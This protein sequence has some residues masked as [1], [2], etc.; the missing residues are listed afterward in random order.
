MLS[1]SFL[2]IDAAQLGVAL[3]LGPER[4]AQQRVRPLDHRHGVDD[5]HDDRVT[6]RGGRTRAAFT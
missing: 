1:L 2:R 4:G 6:G 3:P 5:L